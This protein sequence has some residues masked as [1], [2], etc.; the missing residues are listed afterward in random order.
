MKFLTKKT[1]LQIMIAVILISS[2]SF[3]HAQL[4]SGLLNVSMRPAEPAAGQE[5]V[6]SLESFTYDLRTAQ[7]TWILNEKIVRQGTGAQTFVFETGKLGTASSVRVIVVTNDGQRITRSFT[8]RPADVDLVWEAVTYT[9]PFYKGKALATSKS[10]IKITAIPHFVLASGRRINPDDLIYTWQKDRRVLG[11][12]SGTGK[13]SIIIDGPRLFESARIAVHVSS[14]SNTYNARDEMVIKS[15]DPK[16]LFYEK[17]P[18]EGVKY[19]QAIGQTFTLTQEEITVR[20]EPYFFSGE[21]LSASRV[22]FS[23]TLNGSPIEQVSRINEATLRQED[24]ALSAQ[25]GGIAELSLSVEN[26]AKILQETRKNI[27]LQFGEQSLF[28]RF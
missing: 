22:I 1:I 28:D 2:A 6:V 7:I 13:Q 5:V 25:A 14:L 12:L 15:I 27:F 20:A 9:P 24:N 16:I 19:E 11:S 3:A 8:V 23:W 21:D 18:T 26:I 17:H 4:S 10:K